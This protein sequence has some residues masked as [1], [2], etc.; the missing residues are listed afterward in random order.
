MVAAATARD[1]WAEV[2]AG[3]GSSFDPATVRFLAREAEA[4]LASVARAK[5]S[6]AAGLPAGPPVRPTLLLLKGPPGTGKSEAIKL[7]LA[8]LADAA[9]EHLGAL[10]V[11]SFSEL[12]PKWKGSDVTDLENIMF[13]AANPVGAGVPFVGVSVVVADELGALVD[14]GVGAD[15]NGTSSLRDTI[16]DLLTRDL[17]P[18]YSGELLVLGTVNDGGRVAPAVD[19]RARSVVVGR[20]DLARFTTAAGATL[21]AALARTLHGVPAPALAAAVSDIMAAPEVPPAVEALWSAAAGDLRPLVHAAQM[22][23]E[24]GAAAADAA[25]APTDAGTTTAAAAVAAVFRREA[26]MAAALAQ[27]RHEVAVA[28]A[29]GGPVATRLPDAVAARVPTGSAFAAAL[30]EVA[31]AKAASIAY[32]RNKRAWG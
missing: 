29:T 21:R 6:A 4:A 1:L 13:A 8:S 10:M 28:A 19:S 11:F 12:T 17:P 16:I 31:T 24:A 27:L 3:T 25:A 20:P 5:A 26:A 23:A 32:N 30:G 18:H 7:A 15:I 9:R 14:S 22:A 2:A